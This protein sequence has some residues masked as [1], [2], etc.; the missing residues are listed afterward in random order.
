MEDHEILEEAWL[1]VLLPLDWSAPVTGAAVLIVM[2][3]GT[4]VAA[5]VAGHVTTIVNVSFDELA[6]DTA[7]ENVLAP[8][9]AIRS[10]RS[11]APFF[12]YAPAAESN[13]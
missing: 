12:S 1:K 4:I 9:L 5:P 10:E 3:A 11:F 13:T 8:R 7:A 2:S 6:V